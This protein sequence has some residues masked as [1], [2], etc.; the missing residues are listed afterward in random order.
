M[1]P[2][3]R[4]TMSEVEREEGREEPEADYPQAE[5]DPYLPRTEW[6][7][8]SNAKERRSEMAALEKREDARKETTLVDETA[9]IA[10]DC[11]APGGGGAKNTPSG[12]GSDDEI[13]DAKSA[14]IDEN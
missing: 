12:A 9:E 10:E 14:E 7:H 13:A 4:K 5:R 11:Q 1:D 2:D 6:A 8:H 3:G